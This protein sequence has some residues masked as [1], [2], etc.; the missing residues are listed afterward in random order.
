MLG[1]IETKSASMQAE[2][3]ELSYF[4]I[5]D[6]DADRSRKSALSLGELNRI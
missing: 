2:T 4:E 6:Q 3:E 5:F 1:N